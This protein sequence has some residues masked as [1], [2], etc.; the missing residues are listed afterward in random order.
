MDRHLRR[1]A[2]ASA[3]V[4]VLSSTAFADARE[5]ARSMQLPLPTNDITVFDENGSSYPGSRCASID[6]APLSIPRAPEDIDRWIEEH[7]GLGR[8]ANV[9][10]P[11]AFHV[12]YSQTRRSSEGNIPQSQIDAQIAVLN[13]A[14]SGTGFS[15]TL[16][17]VTRTNNSKWFGMT[18]GSRNET[19]AKSS[20]AISPATTLN[21]YSAKPGQGLLGWATFPWSY[22][23]S[24]YRHGIVIHYGSVPGGYLSPY[25]EGDTGTHEVGH[26]LG[27]Y[28]TFQ[29]GCTE[30]GDYVADTPAE[31]SA[32]YG[33]PT[34]RDSCASAG[35][36]PIT[37]FM[38]YTDDSCMFQF[39]AEQSLR[40]EWATTTYRPSLGGAAI[41]AQQPGTLDGPQLE[42]VARESAVARIS[43]NPFNPR[44]EISFT[45]PRAGQVKVQVFDMRGRVVATLADESFN[46]GQHMLVFD[47]GDLA[48]GVYLVD[49]RLGD[50]R[51]TQRIALIK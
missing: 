22:P 27:L 41:V 13:A 32:A 31:A 8:A 39:T 1:L 7:Y 42:Q 24:D 2:L 3:A 35:L 14:Y 48:S 26:Y 5:D 19:Q 30:P 40:M 34:G 44:T 33:C 45:L 36:D 21:V 6:D 25:N 38:D 15:F 4:L 43:P 50:Q 46:S 49:M 47:G 51:S 17:T 12:I 11:V 9:N 28:H 37:N 18:P 10:I 20:L 29:G 23:E 16:S